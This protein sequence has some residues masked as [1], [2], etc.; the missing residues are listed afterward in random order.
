MATRISL[1]S[2]IRATDDIYI[3]FFFA[4]YAI[5]TLRLYASMISLIFSQ[6][7]PLP[8]PLSF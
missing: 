1:F 8:L 2:L 3:F 6:M 7:L 5:F 4:D